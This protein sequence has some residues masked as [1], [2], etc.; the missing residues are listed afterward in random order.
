MCRVRRILPLM[1]A[2]VPAAAAAF[3]GSPASPDTPVAFVHANVVPMDA[4][5][6]LRDQ[7]VIVSGGKIEAV[8]PSSKTAI[9][10]GARRIDAAGGYL[11]PGLADMHVHVYAPE[12]LTLYAVNGVTSVFNLNGRPAHLVMRRRIAAGELFG[13]TLYSVGPTFDHPRTPEEA[14]AEVDRI[15]AAGWDGVKIYNQVSKA[16]YPALAAEAK[17]KNLILVGHVAREPGFGATLAAGQSI[18]H[19]E[20]YVYTFFNDDPDPSHEVVHALDTY[21]IPKAVAMTKEAGISVIPTLVAFRNI[22]RQATAVKKYLEDPNLAYMMPTMRAALEPAHNT[23]AN[24]FPPEKIP[25]LAV[26]YEFQRQLVKALHDGGVPI[27][28]GT[29]ASWLGVPGFCLLEEIEIFQDLGF[30]PYAA[31]KTATVDAAKLLRREGEFGTLAP[32]K[33]A[34]MILTRGNPLEDVGRLRNVD[35]VMVRGRWIPA[36]GRQAML[37]AIPEAYRKALA[38]MESQVE[39]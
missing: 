34:D 2:L 13:P 19:A 33:R 1:L 15:S 37:E 28:A 39:N 30:T 26:S 18:A 21:R 8:G 12:E 7:T 4:D 11:M 5:R 36:A 29:D 23:Y 9:P 17:R 16:E 35:G 10:A 25:G 6:I 22:V 24:R 20:E 14:V 27:L 3:T 38:K 31:L 32:G